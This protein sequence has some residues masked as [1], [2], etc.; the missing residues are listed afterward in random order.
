ME[1]LLSDGEMVAC[2]LT[3]TLTVE[4]RERTYAIAAF[5]R[6][7]N[8]RIESAKIYREGSAEVA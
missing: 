3:E 1:S 2:Q 5:Y 8:G 4:G 7:R 6:L